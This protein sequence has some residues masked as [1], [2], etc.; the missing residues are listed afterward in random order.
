MDRNLFERILAGVGVALVSLGAIRVSVNASGD[1][2][3]ATLFATGAAI[4]LI[5]GALNFRGVAD[6]TKKRSTQRGANSLATVVL[7]ITILV[8]IQ[9]ISARNVFR[10][11]L[12]RNQR[13]TLAPQ[14]HQILDQ[15]SSDVSVK[16]FFRA[17]TAKRVQ[18]EGLLRQYQKASNRF[19]VEF[20]DPDKQPDIADRY[21]AQYDEIVIEFSNRSHKVTRID[22]T[23]VTNGLVHVTREELKVLYFIG[24]H[25]EK[26]LGS[27][28]QW[29]YAEAKRA[30]EAE[31]YSVQTLSLVEVDRIPD[32]CAA[33]VLA[34]PKKEFLSEEMAILTQYL[35][36]GGSALVM[37]E[38]RAELDSLKPLLDMFH[39]ALDPLVILDERTLTGSG[40][41]MFDATVA[42]VKT[43]VQ[44]DITR[45]FG[46]MTMFPMARSIRIVENETDQWI[47]AQYLAITDNTSWG[48][49]DMNSFTVGQATREGDDI[50]GPL[51]VAA[52]SIRSNQ[53][54][55]TPQKKEDGP[56]SRV[57]FIGDSDFAA[58]SFLYVQG[59]RDFFLNTINFVAQQ[60]D[61]ISIRPVEGLQDRVFLSPAQARFIMVVCFGL[62]PLSVAV[63][64]VTVLIRRRRLT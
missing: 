28:L 34:G 51:P 46:A 4:L 20:F 54:V 15:L 2:L 63:I 60:A 19:R 42:K 3:T 17:N 10:K 22:E 30:L 40:N 57:V 9:A 58:N 35:R 56:V 52:V 8:L 26:N 27:E 41:R 12:T 45:G 24:G 48:E 14:T 33:L 31:G 64:G 16:A 25:D 53:F 47:A 62:L 13:Y 32:D 21:K 29:G 18:A 39:I 55:V 44:H 37:L 23:G 36:N 59:N 7:L 5:Y 11:D 6:F 43:Y 50:A 61:L 49:T 38:P 1:V